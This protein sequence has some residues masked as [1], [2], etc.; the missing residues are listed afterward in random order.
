[1]FPYGGVKVAI[2]KKI[3]KDLVREIYI[4]KE[5]VDLL[6][7][8]I[9]DRN[10]SF[11]NVCFLVLSYTESYLI[12]PLYPNEIAKIEASL[13]SVGFDK[14]NIKYIDDINPVLNSHCDLCPYVNKILND[15]IPISIFK[16]CFF[17]LYDLNNK[18]N[19]NKVLLVFFIDKAQISN[20]F[21]ASLLLEF[22]RFVQFESFTSY[23]DVYRISEN[24]ANLTLQ[25][26]LPFDKNLSLGSQEGQKQFVL[27]DQIMRTMNDV[28]SLYYESSECKGYFQFVEKNNEFSGIKLKKR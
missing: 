4:Y 19:G 27:L 24:A 13:S 17:G 5:A 26:T 21:Y 3:L 28:S 18:W 14:A 2:S 12:S 22:Y 10:A 8:T 15:Y 20:P 9:C 6:R 1:M 7:N 25:K 23:N 16:K 11:F